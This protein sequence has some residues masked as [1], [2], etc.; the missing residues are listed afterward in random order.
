MWRQAKFPGRSAGRSGVGRGNTL[1]AC[2]IMGTA[3]LTPGIGRQ[4]FDALHIPACAYEHPLPI[5]ARG[6][7]GA[8]RPRHRNAAPRAPDRLF[9]RVLRPGLPLAGHDVCPPTRRFS[10]GRGRRATAA[11]G[12]RYRRHPRHRAGRP[13]RER[14]AEDFGARHQSRRVDRDFRTKCRWIR[15]KRIR[16]SRSGRRVFRPAASP[17]VYLP[18]GFRYPETVR[19]AAP[20]S[21]NRVPPALRH[22][23]PGSYRPVTFADPANTFHE[24]RACRGARAPFLRTVNC[25]GDESHDLGHRRARPGAG[26]PAVWTRG[27]A[28]ASMTSLAGDRLAGG[29]A[30]DAA[31]GHDVT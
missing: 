24:S 12:R 19:W 23:T 18:R 4:L 30:E 5:V 14:R 31:D 21:T 15:R 1:G 3:A 8:C 27:T 13:R 17:G 9:P 7:G 25:A 22:A 29:F 11:G 20:R 6:L 26:L 10:S 28:V 16:S 2:S